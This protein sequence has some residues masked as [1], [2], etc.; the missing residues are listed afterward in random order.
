MKK[1]LLTA[2]ISTVTC[3]VA[4]ADNY[5][6]ELE[7]G[8]SNQEDSFDIGDREITSD[9]KGPSLRGRY[10]FSPIDTR[11][12]PL[13]EAAF[14]NKASYIDAGYADLETTDNSTL[15]G[16]PEEGT[17]SLLK[18]SGQVVFN[19]SWLVKLGA[20]RLEQ[21]SESETFKTIGFGG[22]INDNTTVVF[23]YTDLDGGNAYDLA[24]HKVMNLNNDTYL[25]FDAGL[26]RIE[27]DNDSSE[28]GFFIGAKYHPLARL[29]LGL[30]YQHRKFNEDLFFGKG[31][32]ANATYFVTSKFSLS[33]EY[34]TGEYVFGSDVSRFD[35]KAAVRF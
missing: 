19:D 2:L 33:A 16:L 20:H 15:F 23:S 35:V 30:E 32:K 4:L 22:Y 8:Y 27:G 5:Q 34:F 9:R 18:L 6:I 7:G 24:M 17:H 25:S 3:S 12:A 28:S 21:D 1:I 10:Y 31:L 14:L 11:N 29:S 26:G 13:T